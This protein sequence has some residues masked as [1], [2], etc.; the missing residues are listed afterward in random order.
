MDL[1]RNI[2][3]TVWVGIVVGTLFGI[4]LVGVSFALYFITQIFPDQWEFVALPPLWFLGYIGAGI[5]ASLQTKRIAA[6]V[7]AGVWAGFVTMTLVLMVIVL[8]SG[9]L[10]SFFRGS[11]PMTQY[12]FLVA[13]ACIVGA[14]AGTVGS[15]SAHFYGRSRREELQNTFRDRSSEDFNMNS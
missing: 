8:E 3:K 11:D 7:V 2:L 5:A 12:D 14:V 9:R 1:Q 4:G 15:A 6:G 10:V 13:C